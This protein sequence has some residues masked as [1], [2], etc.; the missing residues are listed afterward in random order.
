MTRVAALQTDETVERRRQASLAAFEIGGT[1]PEDRFD[2]IARLA[3]ELFQAPI[4]LVSLVEDDRQW[5]KAHHG[6]GACQA[7]R[8]GSFCGETI[9]G[10]EVFC[11][12]DARADPRF[13]ASPLVTGEPFARFYVGAPLIASDGYRLGALCVLDTAPRRRPSQA[14]RRALSR[15]AAMVVRQMELRRTEFVRSTVTEFAD[16]TALTLLSLDGQG[17]I[18]FVNA[19]ASALFGYGAREMIGQPVDLIIPERLRAAHGAGFGRAIA[20]NHPRLAGRTVEVT[21]LK[22]DGTEFPVEM[23]L[24]VWHGERGIG[25]GAIIR[26]ITERRERDARLLR[27]ASQDTLTGL[28]N[29]SA[30]ED[31]IGAWLKAGEAAG[32]LVADLDGFKE[33]NDSL[34]YEVGDALLQAV[35]VR[36]PKALD[37]SV[38]SARLGGDT[39]AL[40]LPQVRDAVAAGAATARVMEAFAL[41]FEIDGHVC[42]LG[43]SVGAA[44]APEHGRDAEELLASADF[45]LHRVKK[46][47]GGMARLFEPAMRSHSL[48]RRVLRD[49]LLGALR[50]GDLRLHYQPQV[51]LADGSTVGMEALIRW[52]HPVRGLVLPGAFLPAVETS[53]LALPVGWWVLDEACRQMALW[54]DA[55][56]GDVRMAINLFPGQFRDRDLVRRIDEALRRWSLDPARLEIEVTESIALHDDDSSHLRLRQLRE[57]GVRVALDDFGTGYASL[58]TLQRFALTTLKIDRSFVRDFPANRHD[59]AITR[60]MIHLGNDLD[61]ETVAEG[62][63]TVQQET[64][65][66][67][68]GCQVGQGFLYGRAMPG[69]AALAWIAAQAAECES[70]RRAAG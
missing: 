35:A 39:F 37:G 62:I 36:L 16:A 69:E 56:H 55:G 44:L 66:R 38:V 15:L 33:I 14:R 9:R 21:A 70:R 10:D 32:V 40:F 45:A 12:E 61:L 68:L 24:S 7:P 54:R 30:L 2:D 8:A 49:E 31:E 64:A 27:R 57:L 29:R 5:F 34:G 4:A 13:A 51:S 28:L 52:Q 63:E 17:R 22:R 50:N 65:L 19:A 58:S 6:V 20:S 60:A 3:A 43:V 23:T 41:P 59:A 25:I 11:V 18:A 53:T 46:A 48:A 67:A 47:G 42:Q 26:D 1:E